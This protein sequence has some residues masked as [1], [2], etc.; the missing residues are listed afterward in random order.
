MAQVASKSVASQSRKSTGRVIRESLTDGTL[1]MLVG[2]MAIGYL[3]AIL[4]T[5]QSPLAAF[6]EGDMFTGMLVFF[7][8]YMGTVVGRKFKELDHFP[9]MLLA[10]AVLA[11]VANAAI[12]IWS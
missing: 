7:L 3:L 8:L 6:I 4:G 9:P 2:S 12:A 5:E 1:L 10:F 11:P